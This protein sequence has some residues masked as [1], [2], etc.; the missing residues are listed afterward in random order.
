L[1]HPGTRRPSSRSDRG[2]LQ[3]RKKPRPRSAEES[4]SEGTLSRRFVWSNEENPAESRRGNF[5]TA[6]KHTGSGE[7]HR[8]PGWQRGRTVA[9]LKSKPTTQGGE[10][11]EKE[12]ANKIHGNSVAGWRHGHRRGCGNPSARQ[13]KRENGGAQAQ[14]GDSADTK[15]EEEQRRHFWEEA[16]Q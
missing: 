6:A 15:S 16:T 2:A 10:L 3:W 4:R 9:L 7:E 8:G 5:S 13:A 12:P 14:A 1:Q 11:R